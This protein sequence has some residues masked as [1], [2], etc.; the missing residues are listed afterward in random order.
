MKNACLAIACCVLALSGC[1]RTGGKVVAVPE[2]VMAT[3]ASSNRILHGIYSGEGAWRWAAPVFAFKLD[4]PPDGKQAWL[5]MDFTVPSELLKKQT[6]VTV[7][8]RV[9]GGETGRM[10]YRE[11]GRYF[12]DCKVPSQ[13]L[14]QRPAEVEFS[15]NRSFTDPA[16]SRQQGLIVVSAGLKEYEQTAEFR[17]AEGAKS[18]DAYAEILKQRDLQMPVEKQREIMKVFHELKI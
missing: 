18:R 10:T 13:Q 15:I 11:A 8:A 7:L 17:Q 9:N 6:D 12:F 1:R 14:Q 2:I 3:D 5:E 4:P 16:T